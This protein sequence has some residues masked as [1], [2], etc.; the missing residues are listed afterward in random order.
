VALAAAGVLG[1][2]LAPAA[3]ATSRAPTDRRAVIR[4][5]LA[6]LAL[7]AAINVPVVFNVPQQG[8]PRLFAPTWLVICGVVAMVA[9]AIR[10]RRPRPWGALAGVFAAAALLSLTLSVWVRVESAGF[11]ESAS[12]QIAA[13][14]DDG[15]RV[16]LCGVTRTVVEPAPRGAFAVHEFIYDWAAREALLYYT[17]ERAEFSLAGELWSDPCPNTVDVDRVFAFESLV[18]RWRADG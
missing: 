5:V 18:Q 3:V 10:V 17:G 9:A 1:F 6:G 11:T 14:I 16:G 2:R 12:R 7:T 4:T 8:S 15:S 13:E